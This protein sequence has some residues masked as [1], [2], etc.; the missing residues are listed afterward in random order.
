MKTVEVPVAELEKLEAA[1]VALYDVLA[2]HMTEQE[3][4]ALTSITGQIWRVAN[5]RNWKK[6]CK[7][8]TI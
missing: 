7:T 4:F 2:Q 1:R 3:L 8:N 6:D 5:R